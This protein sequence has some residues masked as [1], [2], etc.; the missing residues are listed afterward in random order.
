V[1]VSLKLLPNHTLLAQVGNRRCI[2]SQC[3]ENGV[4]MMAQVW[5]CAVQMRWGF[6]ETNGAIDD[7]H[8]RSVC[9][10]T[11]HSISLC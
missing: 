10:W 8:G 2:L 1:Y 11:W 9:A 6:V 5:R 4:G 7:R 3:A